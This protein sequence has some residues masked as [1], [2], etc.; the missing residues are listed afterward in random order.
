L[1][2][3]YQK[4]ADFWLFYRDNRV[5]TLSRASEHSLSIVALNAKILPALTFHKQVDVVCC[6]DA[7][8]TELFN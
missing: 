3:T 1:V 4:G 6:P 7:H 2:E 8:N 5:G